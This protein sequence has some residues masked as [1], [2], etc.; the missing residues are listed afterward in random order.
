MRDIYEL[1]AR[2]RDAARRGDL[3]A[4]DALKDY[5]V[6]EDSAVSPFRPAISLDLGKLDRPETAESDAVL[7]IANAIERQRRWISY[8]RKRWD[9]EGPIIVSEGDS[10]FQYPF[11]L[12]DT[13]DWLMDTFAVRSLGAG[14]DTLAEMIAVDEYRSVIESE[15]A[16]IFLFSA[17]GND[18]L[19]GGRLREFLRPWQDGF[20]PQD[21]IDE[22]TFTPFLDGIA[23]GYGELFDSLRTSFPRLR[24]LIHGYDYARPTPGGRW[25]FEPLETAGV[26]DSARAE[27]VRHLIDVY[28]ARLATLASEVGAEHIDCRR[29]VGDDAWH[30]ELHP[31]DAGFRLVARAFAERI[32]PTAPGARAGVVSAATRAAARRLASVQVGAPTSPLEP[33]LATEAVID[34]SLIGPGGGQP[35]GP[36]D[37]TGV[38]QGGEAGTPATNTNAEAEGGPVHPCS[39]LAAW[40]DVL[41]ATDK[42]AFDHVR[43]LKEDLNIPDTP[44][45]IAQRKELWSAGGYQPFERIL[46][47]SNVFQVSYLARGQ[48]AARTICRIT[49]VNEFGVVRGHGTGFLVAPGLL[50]TNHHVLEN[51]AAAG[52]SFALFDYEYDVKD[53]FLIAQRF[54]LDPTLFFTDKDLD[55]T[56]VKVSPRSLRGKP[57]ADYGHLVLIRESGKA[58]KKEYVSIIQHGNG[59]PKQIA[60]RDSMILGRMD[61]YIYYTTDTNP[62]SSG[63]PVL[64]DD[65]FPVALHH[66]TVPDFDRPCAYVANR[67]IRISSIFETLDRSRAAGNADAAGILRLLTA[68]P[69]AASAGRSGSSGA[70]ALTEWEGPPGEAVRGPVHDP[71]YSN[72]AGYDETFLG[73]RVRLP[74]VDSS[75]LAPLIDGGGTLLHYQNFSVAMHRGRRLAAF[76]AANV[77]AGR[78]QSPEPDRAY[79]RDD[80]GGLG[81]HDDEK[82]FCDPRI[83]RSHQ[84]PD[85]FFTKDDQAFDRGHI[86][87][88][89]A[90]TWGR[91]YA[92]VQR[93]NGDTFHTTNCSPQVKDFNRSNLGGLWGK[94]ENVVYRQARTERLVVLAGPVLDPSDQTFV[95]LD[96]LGQVRVQ[97]PSRYWKVIVAHMDGRLH[98]FP[99][100]LEQDLADVPLEFQVTAEWRSRLKTLRDIEEVTGIVTFPPE[101]HDAAGA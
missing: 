88:R 15:R 9:Y 44:E 71:D 8:R 83:D 75:L 32:A 67:G 22:T 23:A 33:G 82:W 80:L 65:W 17:G 49:I 13:I 53:T 28:N 27:V 11:F 59:D 98:V 29:L 30:D 2:V 43:K 51:K 38:G 14:G 6:L 60:M 66:R 81:R 12:K 35:G 4:L 74:T 3:E 93:A 25:L 37:P 19:R 96:D 76:T 68:G 101:L 99:F 58:L 16:D 85:V 41:D 5:F 18:M 90:V 10:W 56:F 57:I 86:V 40:R 73:P 34:A 63:S 47:H 52:S 24:V 92:D 61:D 39:S 48:S 95:G 42:E 97:I 94:L 69:A 77:D 21:A 50:L 36:V 62:G 84:L 87:R 26:P 79:T 70:G 1:Q 55:F 45:R 20:S 7:A 31:T 78:A 100:L 46:G 72:R 64:T 91:T 89:Q 54:N